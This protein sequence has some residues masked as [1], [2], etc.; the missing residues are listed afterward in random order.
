MS[1]QPAIAA[2]FL[3]RLDLSATAPATSRNDADDEAG[4]RALATVRA[5]YQALRR[6]DSEAASRLV[7]PERRQVGPYAPGAITRYYA[8]LAEPLRLT[9]PCVAVGPYA[10][11][12]NETD[13][14]PFALVTCTLGPLPI[15]V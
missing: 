5:F 2:A 11:G 8:G 6:A 7:I 15:F 12:A 10:V 9:A 3:G 4:R 13:S 1:L 14:N